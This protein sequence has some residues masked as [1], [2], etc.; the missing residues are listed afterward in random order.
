MGDDDS[1]RMMMLMGDDDCEWMMMLM[2]DDERCWCVLQDGRLKAGDQLLEVD[3]R[4]LVG[5]SQDK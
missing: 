2:D 4:S 1:E 5:L 3:G